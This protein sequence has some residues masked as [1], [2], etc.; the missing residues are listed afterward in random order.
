MFTKSDEEPNGIKLGIAK[1]EGYSEFGYLQFN[2][3]AILTLF[4]LNFMPFD[5]EPTLFT[6]NFYIQQVAN[7]LLP[8]SITWIALPPQKGAATPTFRD[9]LGTSSHV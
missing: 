6:F 7:Q 9:S 1:R 3:V 4:G 2:N 5:E 8:V